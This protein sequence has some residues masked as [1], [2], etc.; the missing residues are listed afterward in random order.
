MLWNEICSSKI[1]LINIRRIWFVVELGQ[2]QMKSNLSSTDNL[3]LDVEFL[4]ISNNCLSGHS[5][6]W[7]NEICSSKNG[8]INIWRILFAVELGQS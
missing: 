6:M 7:W 5:F 2:S 4:K 8:P 1:G 3:V